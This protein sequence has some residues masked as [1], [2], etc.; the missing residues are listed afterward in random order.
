MIFCDYQKTWKSPYSYLLLL[1]LLFSSTVELK[2][3]AFG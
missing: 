2:G 1:L 3:D